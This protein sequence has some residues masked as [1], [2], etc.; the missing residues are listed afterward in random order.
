MV[1]SA[2][3]TISKDNKLGEMTNE[4]T[5]IISNLFRYKLLRTILVYSKN[6]DVNLINIYIYI[7]MF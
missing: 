5:D 3:K 2:N 7:Y 1:L 4:K 6:F